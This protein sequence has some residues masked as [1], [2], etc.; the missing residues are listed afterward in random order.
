MENQGGCNA[1][2]AFTASGAIEGLASLTKGVTFN[3]STQQ[4]VDCSS[5]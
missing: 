1:A 5:Q 4:L 3:F 2:W